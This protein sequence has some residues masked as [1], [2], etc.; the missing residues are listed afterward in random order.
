[1][2]TYSELRQWTEVQSIDPPPA[3]IHGL[4]SGW[5]CAGAAWDSRGRL[6]ALA[7]WLGI[8]LSADD[9]ALLNRVHSDL[10]EGIADD[11][12]GFSPLLPDDEV[13]VNERAR[14]VSSWCSG[15]LY[16]FGMTGK[17][18]AEDLSEEV[19]EAL[20]DL[21]KIAALSDDVPEDED[22]ESDLTEIME[23]V[24][25]AAMLIHAECQQKAVH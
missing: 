15:F 16:G 3:E 17:F 14:E 19:T 11:A 25:M 12:F 6:A 7:E 4:M 1:M 21:G 2:V 8:D 9:A 20:T 18:A 10:A 24:R 13:A 5:L 23:Y 22:N